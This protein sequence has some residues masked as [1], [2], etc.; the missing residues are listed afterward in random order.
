M[1]LAVVAFVFFSNVW[2]D[3]LWYQQLGFFEVYVRENLARILTFAGGF[4]LMFGAVYASIRL[5]YRAR[6]VYARIPTCGTTSAATRSS[7]NRCAV[8]S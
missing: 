8:W 5:A 3:V 6:P 1:A 7:L 4:V 2:T